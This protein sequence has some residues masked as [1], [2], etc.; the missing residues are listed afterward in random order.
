MRL[1][2][3]II[4][5][6]LIGLVSHMDAA[7]HMGYE[8]IKDDCA[9]LFKGTEVITKTCRIE[10]NDAIKANRTNNDKISNVLSSFFFVILITCAGGILGG[11]VSHHNRQSIRKRNGDITIDLI[12]PINNYNPIIQLLRAISLADVPDKNI[13]VTGLC[14]ALIGV[15]FLASFIGISYDQLL[16]FTIEKPEIYLKA[17]IMILGVSGLSGF[18]GT[19]LIEGLAENLLTNQVK[20]VKE[21]QENMSKEMKAV[22][23]HQYYN[24]GYHI[25]IEAG[26]LK[27]SEN[28]RK[29]TK[30]TE[31]KRF[32]LKSLTFAVFTDEKA[33]SLCHLAYSCKR[34]NE[35]EE[36]LNYVSK[37]IELEQ[38]NILYRYN[39][40]CYLALLCYPIDD[41]NKEIIIFANTM[42]NPK[43]LSLRDNIIEQ[44][45]K[46]IKNSDF[47]NHS[48]K[49]EIK[50]LFIKYIPEIK[51]DAI[52]G[53]K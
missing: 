31:A 15:P 5:V 10:I 42:K 33:T 18:L 38:D 23:S 32:F 53:K 35:F 36:A 49:D 41:I 26:N 21:Q 4:L 24:R 46:D 14:S 34:L 37:A 44:I 8:S 39:K 19:K 50:K 3:I 25:M 20:E 6:S 7:K 13:V 27:D 2:V 28:R 12:K 52:K 48:C 45:A 29:A 1:I 40:I 47:A 30:F 16:I 9:L 17:I 22:I 11:I 43:D 51:D